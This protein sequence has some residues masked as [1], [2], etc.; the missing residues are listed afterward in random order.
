MA[1]KY[2]KIDPRI[3]RDEKFRRLTAVQK[4]V[5]VYCLTA[6]ANRCGIFAFS[7]AAA[8]Q[9]LGLT[10]RAFD[11][12]FAIVTEAMAWRWDSDAWVLYLFATVFAVRS[13]RGSMHPAG[14]TSNPTP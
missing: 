14:R 13:R 6:Q 5:A 2:R 9:E 4:L 1:Q 11:A 12:E 3:W 8:A 10:Q 7:T